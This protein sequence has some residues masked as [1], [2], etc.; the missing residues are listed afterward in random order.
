[1]KAIDFIKEID[2]K[3]GGEHWSCDQYSLSIYMEQ[4]A[5]KCKLNSPD[6]KEELEKF[7]TWYWEN[8]HQKPCDYRASDITQA[9]GL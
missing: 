4:Y 7:I 1:M 8:V 5:E 9:Y 2:E 3:E 6:L